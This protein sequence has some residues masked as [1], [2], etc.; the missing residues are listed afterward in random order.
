MTKGNR[1]VPALDVAA[2][3]HLYDSAL[4]NVPSR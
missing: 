4:D 1:H 2:V 3:S